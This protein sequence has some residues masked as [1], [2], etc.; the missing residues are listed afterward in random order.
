[1]A[2]RRRY[3]RRNG[4]GRFWITGFL[5]TI[6]GVWGYARF[7]SPVLEGPAEEST[8]A[9]ATDPAA[10]P[11]L[12]ETAPAE[13]KPEA[14]R[15]I[16]TRPESPAPVVNERI[17]EKGAQSLETQR[18]ESTDRGAK[19]F[20]AGMQELSRNELIPARAH[21]SEAL[22]LGLAN[23]DLLEARAALV[24]I[25]AETIFSATI[26]PDDPLVRKHVVSSG[27]SLGKIAK[28]YDVTPDLLAAI[29]GIANKNIIR[30]G[31]EL[32]VIQG[33]FN[34]LVDKSSY[35]MDIYLQNTFVRKYQVGLGAN[36]STPKGEWQ[37]GTK[38][39]N[40]TYYP[41][42]GGTIVAADDPQNPLGEHW[43]ELIGVGGAARGKER[44]GIHGTIAPQSI[45]KSESMG[46]IRMLNEDVAEVF[47]LL[48]PSK[49][50]V[51]VR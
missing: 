23:R 44:Y 7:L 22:T 33:P 42:R 13:E 12:P 25:G 35:E 26:Y 30:V 47:T 11:A 4:S 43:I 40:P 50:R 17:T 2:R 36:D 18:S 37:V 24:R 46:C 48:V 19:L 5:V 38:L 15:L 49:S 6:A 10:D 31:Q 1:M 32:K 39:T 51:V 34:A 9:S 41:P 14:P 20:A 28:M 3:R 45:G 27:E 21:L 29:N 8:V 16:S